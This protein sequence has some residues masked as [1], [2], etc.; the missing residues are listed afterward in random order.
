MIALGIV[1]GVIILIL[2]IPVGV[3]ARY[4]GAASVQAVVGPLRIQILPEK[5]K[6][7][8]QLAKAE[9]KKAEKE[10]KKAE[11]KEKEAADKLVYQEPEPKPEQTLPE[12]IRGLLPFARL[13]VDA[14]SSIFLRLTVKK[15]IVHVRFGGDDPEKLADTYTKTVILIRS[16]GPVLG[17]HF[18]VKKS[19]ISVVPD[20]LSEQTDVEAELYIRYLVFDLLGIALKYGVRGLKLFFRK[21]KHDK[22]LMKAQGLI[23]TEHKG[24]K[25]G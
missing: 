20:F 16:L 23:S 12:K 2:L 7:R 1:L 10:K 19:D 25:V 14:L 15:M 17:R 3:H 6:T 9:Q 22:E 18:R 5:P 11:K 4:D 24:K 8:K 21:K 13:A